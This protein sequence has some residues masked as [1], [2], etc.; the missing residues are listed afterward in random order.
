[1]RVVI[2][3]DT[4]EKHEQIT[5][6]EG[7]LLIHCGDFT[8]RGVYFKMKDF[9]GW[10]ASQPHKHKVFIS[11]NHELGLDRGSYRENKLDLINAFA[12][13]GENEVYYLENSSVT[14][15]GLN[16]YGSP[17]TPF[18]H[19]WAWNIPRGEAIAEKWAQ[20]PEDTNI[21]VTH[22]PAYG[23]LDLVNFEEGRDSHQGCEELKKRISQ[24]KQLKI[25]AFGHLHL[26]G[27]NQ[28]TSDGVV[29]ANGAIC[30]DDHRPIHS[31]VVVD[32]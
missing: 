32:I 12:Q 28:F 23:M 27:G 19:D 17:Y 15:E 10:F 6:P 18:F 22:G 5:L 4:H 21:L 3:S 31:P 14:I 30:T 25:H 1:M 8:N 13:G 2:I 7:D 24:L 9:L 16:I 26:G 20:I 29:F 11:G